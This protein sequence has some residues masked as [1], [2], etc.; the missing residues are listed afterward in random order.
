MWLHNE[1]I[2]KTPR[3]MTIGD[4]TYPRQVFNDSAL[5]ET[6][7]ITPYEMPVQLNQRYYWNNETPRDVDGL[8]EQMISTIKS[9]V[10]SRLKSTDWQVIRQMDG[11]TAMSTELKAYRAAIRTEG[12]AK[13]SEVNALVT[14]DD[15][16][17]YEATPF[18]EVRKIKHTS[19]DGVETYGD[20]LDEP[21]TRHINLTMHFDAVDPLAE[22]D[23]AFVS[24]TENN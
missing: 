18:T 5:L 24:L 17:L 4:V 8:K 1:T 23:P 6:L 16:M 21:M 19:E 3:S 10:G 12:D 9:Q 13:E 14:L 15:V 7:G 11:G 20:E 2:I 22:I